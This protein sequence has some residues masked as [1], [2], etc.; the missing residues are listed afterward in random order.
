VEAAFFMSPVL[1]NARNLCVVALSRL[2]LVST[3]C[4]CTVSDVRTRLMCDVRPHRSRLSCL[5]GYFQACIL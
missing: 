3:W 4:C 5:N 1:L 2:S